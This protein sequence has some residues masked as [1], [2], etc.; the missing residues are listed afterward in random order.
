MRIYEG[1]ARRDFEEVFRA[2]GADLD[3]RGMRE[4]LLVEVEDGFLVQGLS[5]IGESSNWSE[6]V[7]QI[8]KHSVMYRDEEVA[9]LMDGAF[10]RRGQRHPPSIRPYETSLRVIG[11][12]L[13]ETRPRDVFLFEQGGAYV[14]RT[15]FIDQAHVEHRLVEFTSEDITALIGRAPGLRGKPQPTGRM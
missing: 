5:P 15:L 7:G 13:D 3:A 1:G 10:G 6:S 4:I 12:Y 9:T 14:I 8:G 2:I 11:R